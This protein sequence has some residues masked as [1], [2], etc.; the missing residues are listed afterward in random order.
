MP[1]YIQLLTLT[2]EGRAKMLQDPELLLRAQYEIALPG[3]QMLGQYGVLGDFDFV[4]IVEAPDND[5]VARFSLELG[6]KAGAHVA[7]LPAI[8][9]G[10]F[11]TVL[12]QA[13]PKLELGE[14]ALRPPSGG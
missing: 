5:V 10:R 1:I 8:P 14:R 4:C 6:V 7:T 13:A 11:E 9:L 3:V 2:L 12:R